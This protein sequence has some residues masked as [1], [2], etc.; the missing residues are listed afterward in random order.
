MAQYQLQLG[1]AKSSLQQKEHSVQKL[2]DQVYSLEL[3]LASQVSLPSVESTSSEAGFCKEVFNI[4]PGTVNQHTGA[5]QYHLQD[6]PFLL[7]KQVRFED[8]TSSPN[9]KPDADLSKPSSQPVLDILLA[10][11][12]LSSHSHTSTSFS[13]TRTSPQNRTFDIGQIAPLSG[14]PQDAVT[15]A[16]EVSAAAAA[17]QPSKEFHCMRKPKIIKF[18]GGYS[19]DAE[20]SFRSWHVDILAHIIDHELD[21]K[22]A[23]Q[24]IK[25][26]TL[27]SAC[28]EVEF[29]LD[30]CGGEIEY[31]DLPQHLTI[32]F[33]GGD[34]EANL[35]A[36]FYSCSQHAKELEEVFVE[37]A[38][39]LSAI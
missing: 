6:Q 21:N 32:A 30:L 10:L 2:Q 24:L 22:A 13:G 35:L 19:V 31:Q 14:N 17:A 36:E 12:N 8:N 26:H 38:V 28:H 29:Q 39:H 33:Q 15:I 11:L 27:H 4:L 1:T 16:A 23:I 37:A 3:L 5:A 9:L 18:K 34:D 25:D 7:Q 20:L